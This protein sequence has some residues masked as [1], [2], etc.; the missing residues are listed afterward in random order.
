MKLRLRFLTWE[1]M[2]IFFVGI[3]FLYEMWRQNSESENKKTIQRIENFTTIRITLK[4]VYLTCFFSLFL[5]KTWAKRICQIHIHVSASTI[6]WKKRIV[7]GT[8]FCLSAL[9]YMVWPWAIYTSCILSRT[10]L[11]RRSGY[12]PHCWCYI[13]MVAIPHSGVRYA[14]QR[15]GKYVHISFVS[16]SRYAIIFVR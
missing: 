8:I 2:E 3:S 4:N 7:A 12:V 14:R 9:C 13:R 11:H 10:I 5:S 15:D 6:Q 1:L 16:F